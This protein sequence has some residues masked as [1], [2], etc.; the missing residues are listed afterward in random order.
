MS[1]I[2]R[3]RNEPMPV[4][5]LRGL[6]A[7]PVGFDRLARP[8]DND[9][10]C[11]LQRVVDGR[12]VARAALDQRVPPHGVAAT[13]KRRSEALRLRLVAVRVAEE[14]RRLSGIA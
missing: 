10:V 4:A 5:S 8:Q 1:S 12:G 3:E 11:G 7:H 2:E 14:N 6:V 13:L 9:G